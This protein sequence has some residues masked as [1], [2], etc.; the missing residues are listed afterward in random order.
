MKFGE[1]LIKLIKKFNKKINREL[2][3]NKIFFLK[4]KNKST[5][6]KAFIVFLN[7]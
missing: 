3:Y 1:K 2:T 5:Q 4:L 6:K 7:Q